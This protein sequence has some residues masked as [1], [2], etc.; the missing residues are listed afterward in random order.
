MILFADSGSTKTAW[1]LYDVANNTRKYFD[2]VGINPIIHHHEE[3]YQKIY[4]NSEL[5][6]TAPLVTEIKFFGAGCSSP[7]RN[8]LAEAAL[9]SVFTNA[10]IEIDHDMKAAAYAICGNKWYK[11]SR[12]IV[13]PK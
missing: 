3:I 5:V 9:K 11:K 12:R 13:F 4:A 8:R 7:D 10:V 6:A 1:L 2:T